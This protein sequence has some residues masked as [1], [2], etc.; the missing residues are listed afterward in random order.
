MEKLRG[1]WF[2]VGYIQFLHICDSLIDLLVHAYLQVVGYEED[3]S[4]RQMIIDRVRMRSS[5]A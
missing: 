4:G 2:N 1:S 5:M 3:L